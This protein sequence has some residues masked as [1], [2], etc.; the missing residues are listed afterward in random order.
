MHQAQASRPAINFVFI[1]AGESPQRVQGWL[2]S[3]KLPLKNVLLDARM[4]AA[5]Q[6]KA[7]GFPTTLFFDAKGEL[8]SVRMGELS[9]AT[10]S[11]RLEDL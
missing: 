11:E 7:P 9:A 5:A 2:Q 10:L 3:H 4:Q 8:V 6:F 1:N